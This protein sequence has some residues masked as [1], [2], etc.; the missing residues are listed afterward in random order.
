MYSNINILRSTLWKALF[1]AYGWPYAVAAFLK[2]FQDLLAFL[3]PQLLR[4]LLSY[5]SEY[6]RAR[7]GPLGDRPSKLEG[8]AVAA[9]MFIASIIQ[10]VALNQVLQSFLCLAH[11]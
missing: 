11:Y 8:F 9:I 4:W 5:I 2:I 7:F 6:Q 10:T 1:I 3:Q